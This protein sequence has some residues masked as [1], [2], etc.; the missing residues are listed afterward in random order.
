MCIPYPP[1]PFWWD[2][3]YPHEAE[4][5]QLIQ[6]WE[7]HWPKILNEPTGWSRPSLYEWGTIEDFCDAI[8][9]TA[10]VLE[11]QCHFL[12]APIPL[13]RAKD[14]PVILLKVGGLIV[15]YRRTWT[16]TSAYAL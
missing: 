15:V 12:G 2:P 10:W 4:K 7:K 11:A 3:G 1:R 9:N 6:L 13:V 8:G 16:Q 5:Q 14:Y